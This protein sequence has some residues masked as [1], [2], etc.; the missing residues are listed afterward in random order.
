MLLARL[1]V[2]KLLGIHMQSGNQAISMTII[3]A[4]TAGSILVTRYA[5]TRS[6]IVCE[7][8]LEGKKNVAMR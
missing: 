8:T 1:V 3:I 4:M 2:K 5:K 7:V 6:Y